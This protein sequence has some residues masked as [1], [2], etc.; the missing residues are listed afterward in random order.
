MRLPW[1]FGRSTADPAETDTDQSAGSPA[2]PIPFAPEPPRSTGAWAALPPI[3]RAVGSPPLVAPADA[4]FD[5][6]PG[7]HPLPSILETLGH[8]VTTVAPTGLVGA[9]VHAVASL[10]SGAPLV[11]PPVQRR[12]DASAGD[13]TGIVDEPP[14][15][16]PP[17]LARDAAAATAAASDPPIRQLGVVTPSAAV[18]PP[19]RSLTRAEPA[20]A[21]PDRSHQPLV[22]RRTQVQAPSAAAPAT[23]P[24][25]GPPPS[26]AGPTAPAAALDGGAAPCRTGC[27][28]R[29]HAEHGGPEPSLPRWAGSLATCWRPVGRGSLDPRPGRV[30][31]GPH[32]GRRPG[33]GDE[34]DGGRRS[35][36]DD[37][38]ATN[39]RGEPGLG[40]RRTRRCRGRRPDL[41]FRRHRFRR[42][43]RPRCLP[44]A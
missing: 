1:P 20:A 40:G 9:P 13:P 11:P 2:G 16:S 8:D 43:S 19:D 22:S 23:A 24:V 29:G 6:V 12:A 3:Q 32:P 38:P 34:P 17:S 27:A 30:G 42:V 25:A 18:R 33:L 28:A 14:S 10:T 35:A 41:A 37:D 31:R 36:A 26:E 15:F 39:D 21:P 7:V 5:A 44:S 4:F